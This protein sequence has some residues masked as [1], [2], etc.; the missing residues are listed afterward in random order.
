MLT[1]AR[2][3]V[4]VLAVLTLGGCGSTHPGAAAV[5]DDKTISMKSV[6][7]TAEVYCLNSI[8]AAKE[9]GAA[10]SEDNAEIRRQAVA[11]TVSLIVARK[12]ADEEGVA[13]PEPASYEVPDSDL[14]RVAAAYKGIDPKVVAQVI[15]DSRELFELQVALGA[16]AAGQPVTEEN[17]EQLAG[18][19]QTV[20]IKAFKDYDVDFAPR[21][22][23]SD[24]AETVA[25][26]GSL[27]A[28]PTDLGE[29]EP[30]Q[31][32]AAQRCS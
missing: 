13:R 3:A 5:V 28:A 8:L 2:A 26:T 32:P 16:K 21:F 9:Q 10:P 12:L 7:E 20:I 23:L 4:L 14:D 17:S 19:G 6:D 24:S 22:G 18:A 29:D 15:E 31:L 1:R 25:A 11:R 30:N 27:S